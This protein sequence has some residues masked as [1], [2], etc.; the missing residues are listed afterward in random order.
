VQWYGIVGPAKLP[1]EITRR[2]NTEI[3][4]AIGSPA[5]QQ[6]L[7]GEAIAVMP[8]TPDEFGQFIQAD[9]A[10]W[11]ALARERNIRLDD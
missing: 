11:S 2:L 3:N 6:R 4:R 8:M 7:A 10:R 1:A 5:L 9:I